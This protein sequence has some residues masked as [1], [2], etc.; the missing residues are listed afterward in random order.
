MSWK[1]LIILCLNVYS[2]NLDLEYDLWVFHTSVGSAYISITRYWTEKSIIW[3]HINALNFGNQSR[4]CMKLIWWIILRTIEKQG[5]YSNSRTESEY[6]AL[7]ILYGRESGIGFCKALMRIFTISSRGV[8][9]PNRVVL[10]TAFL[11]IFANVVVNNR[12]HYA[13]TY[14]ICSISI[15]AAYSDSHLNYHSYCLCT[16]S[17]HV[18]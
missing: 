17:V 12:Y 10:H 3:K 4:L 16:V 9:R 2:A 18:V 15:F 5:L 1:L 8:Y 14:L 13:K 6:V 7:V 11:P